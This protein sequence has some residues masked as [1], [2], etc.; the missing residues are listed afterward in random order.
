MAYTQ[1]KVGTTAL[2]T[3]EPERII[4]TSNIPL[5]STKDIEEGIKNEERYS[6][7]I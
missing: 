5:T 3:V 7:R 6:P 2:P 4:D 1:T